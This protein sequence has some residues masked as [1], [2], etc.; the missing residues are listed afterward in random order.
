MSGLCPSTGDSKAASVLTPLAT[1]DLSMKVNEPVMKSPVT[2]YN[3]L[4]KGK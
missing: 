2:T 3:K 1:I 4:S